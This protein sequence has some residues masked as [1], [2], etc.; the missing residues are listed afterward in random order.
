MSSE[1]L[2]LHRQ[3]GLT[4]GELAQIEA[5]LGRGPNGTELAMY[6]VMW[7]EHCSYKSSKIHLRT[8]P[9]AG[10][11]VLVGP[12]QDAGAV[13]VG[14]GI[15]VVFKIESH[16]HPSAIEPYQGAA[17]GVGGI[18]R[19]IVSMGA[20]PV[21]LLDPLLF[22]PLTE[23]RNRW[24]FAG[25][26]AG[27]GGYG[28]CI[29]VP[30]VGGEIRFADAHTAD[31]TVD[32]MCVGIADAADLITTQSRT[33]Q[34]GSLL[35]LYGATTG[36]D[37]IGGVSVLA[38]AT[39]EDGA[40]GSRP[41]VQIGDPFAE[42]L[43]IEASLE[44]VAGGSLEGLQDL[45]GA[46]IT[47][48]VSESAT[49]AGMGASLDLDAVPLREPGMVP[50]EILTSESQER[51]LAIV[52]PSK[53]DE[54]RS[55]C[56]RWGLT[57]AVI[58]ELTPGGTLTVRSG[59][60][61]VAE[62]AVSSLADEG[63]VYDRP[64][65]PPTR[66]VVSGDDPTFVPFE[67]DLT[68]AVLTVLTAPN[69]ASKRWAFEQYDR[70]VQGNTIAGPDSDAAIVRVAGTLKGLALSTDSK[71]RFGRLDPFLGAV[72]A[73]AESARNVAVT[74][75]TP[76]AITNCLNFGNP[77]RPEVM[78]ELTESIRGIRD[79][80][81]A[82]ETPVTGGNVSLYNESGGSA[83]W[84]TPVIGMLGLL[85]DYRL[86][87]PSSFPRPGLAIYLAGE[88]FAELGGSEFAEGAVLASAHDCGDG[89]LV[90]ALLEAAIG[91]GHGFAVALA[92]DLPSHV[93]LFSES[94]S[95]AV[96]SVEPGDE[97]ALVRLAAKH[98]VPVARLG[99]TGGPRAL[100]EGLVDVPV[101]D[102]RDAWE[103]AIPRLLGET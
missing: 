60:A 22:G 24:L 36:R 18:V 66:S 56:G 5:T 64:A 75:A 59:G 39:L 17:T 94:A 3:L 78:W 44:L 14:D 100:V 102:L 84:P 25:V 6:S 47:C 29:G 52:H 74:G 99:E 68:E 21:A 12:G 7:S 72:H 65:E 58:G 73:V 61:V 10:P 31:P 76:I 97:E 16:S 1:E 50:F 53:L 11:A 41:S 88:T 51:M 101:D 67:K 28:N 2:A 96:V 26:I 62:V 91:G 34:A 57:T 63:P 69:V 43:L 46:G 89:G 35:V 30:T 85:E 48:A 92:G 103:T 79:A 32:V 38:S 81:L 80:C 27:I 49:R 15:A 4:D 13:D 82:F 98:A 55:V 40:E 23:E 20:R 86:R 42:K 90:I 19:D 70:V 8:L 33:A 83:I 95:R 9:T 93:A 87:V 54:V 45:G 71:S 77:E 37:G